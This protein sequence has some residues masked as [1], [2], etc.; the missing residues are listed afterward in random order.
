MH[1]RRVAL[2]TLVALVA[3]AGNSLL[4]RAALRDTGIDA[5]S[6]T[7]IRIVCGALALWLIVRVA[8]GRGA[9]RGLEAGV[10]H[11]P[12]SPMRRRSPSRTCR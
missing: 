6:F 9:S 10:R 8:Q 4:C 3:F 11:S 5:A 2:L 12:C 1:P 7:A